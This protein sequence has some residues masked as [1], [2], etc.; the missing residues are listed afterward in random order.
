MTSR[1]T[2]TTKQ[3]TVHCYEEGCG[4]NATVPGTNQW[5]S[6]YPMNAWELRK[7]VERKAPASIQFTGDVKAAKAALEAK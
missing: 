3:M 4:F 6:R 1:C 5:A 7:W 2:E